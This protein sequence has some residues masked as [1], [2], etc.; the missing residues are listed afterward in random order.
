VIIG[1]LIPVGTGFRAD[2]PS[3][4]PGFVS[5]VPKDVE[6]VEQVKSVDA[7]AETL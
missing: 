7:N 4:K 6:V 5:A 3:N 1:R 2:N